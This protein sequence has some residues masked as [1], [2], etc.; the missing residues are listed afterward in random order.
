M[1]PPAS[2]LLLEPSEVGEQW[3]EDTRRTTDGSN[4]GFDQE[5]L[6]GITHWQFING[7]DL[8]FKQIAV[9][10]KEPELAA[11]GYQLTR[12]SIEPAGEEYLNFQEL[13]YGE[14][15]IAALGAEPVANRA[16]TLLLQGNL[17]V[18]VVVEPYDDSAEPQEQHFEMV[19]DYTEQL[20]NSWG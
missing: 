16:N 5:N 15:G 2:D 13:S 1:E 10:F 9:L 6:H 4:S 8:F 20:Y 11:D 18:N 7:E 3:E 19:L 17:M 14:E 12:N